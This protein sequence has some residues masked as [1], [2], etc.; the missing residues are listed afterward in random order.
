MPEKKNPYEQDKEPVDVDRPEK[1]PESAT[2]GPQSA[3]EDEMI[4]FSIRIPKGQKER[5]ERYLKRYKGLAL[6]SFVRQLI[7]EWMV[8]EKLW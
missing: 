8:K 1:S 5:L 7:T 3:D 6:S 4:T 2:G